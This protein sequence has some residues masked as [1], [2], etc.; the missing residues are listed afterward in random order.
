M[1]ETSCNFANISTSELA[2]I[3]WS[4]L[5]MRSRILKA[6]MATTVS[7][8]LMTLVSLCR[9]RRQFWKNSLKPRRETVLWAIGCKRWH[10]RKFT[11]VRW[12]SW[13][14]TTHLQYPWVRVEIVNSA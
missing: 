11:Q 14:L 2:T 5:V 3:Y 9:T 12:S 6:I 10:F 13:A 8:A 1:A 4:R 7:L